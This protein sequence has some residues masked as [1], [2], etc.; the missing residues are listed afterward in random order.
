MPQWSRFTS[1]E[2]P[3]AAAGGAAAEKAM[4]AADGGMAVWIAERLGQSAS[5]SA[6]F[7]A[8][9]ERSDTTVI[10]VARARYGFG[11]GTGGEGSGGGGG[12]SVT[13]I[14]WI[15]ITAAGSRFK[16]LRPR[17]QAAAV[18]ALVLVAGGVALRLASHPGGGQRA[19]ALIGRL[20]RREGRRMVRKHRR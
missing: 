6:V 2:R 9:V 13:P 4:K 20:V 5:A 1:E 14:G 15:E 8:P 11:A 12:V 18:A 16:P 3:D 7:A 19:D 10:P 17:G